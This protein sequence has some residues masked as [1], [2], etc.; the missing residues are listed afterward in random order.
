[1]E[2]EQTYDTPHLIIGQ[3]SALKKLGYSNRKC[4]EFIT[5]WG[6]CISYKTLEN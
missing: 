4:A 5:E 2:V 3:I 1:M 6:F